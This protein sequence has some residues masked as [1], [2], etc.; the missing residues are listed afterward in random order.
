[1]SSILIIEDEEDLLSTLKY[2]LEHAGYQTHAFMTGEEGLDWATEHGPPSLALL[3]VMLPGISGIE[4]CYRLR[5]HERTCMTPVMFLSA[6]G[7]DIDRVVGFELGA[8]DYLVKPFNVREL[9]LRIR[10]ILRRSDQSTQQQES[11]VI[12][13]SL[14]IDHKRHQVWVAGEEIILTAL[15]FKLLA[16]LISR[17]G[18]VQSRDTLLADVWDVN[19]PVQTRTVD[20][21]VK[22]L[23]EKLGPIGF[24][25]ETIRGIGYRFRE[26]PQE[27]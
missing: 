7:E 20:V 19:V 17:K 18:W 27:E 10:A 4:V 14:K 21:H 1:M 24:A 6:R 9:L 5:S 23:R 25:V 26:L 2:N 11:Q 13:G 8:D 12:Y 22:R 3:D 15:E 16:V